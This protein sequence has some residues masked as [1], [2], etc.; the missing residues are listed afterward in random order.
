MI[1]LI[2]WGIN[3]IKTRKEIR[4]LIAGGINTVVGYGIYALMIWLNLHYMI[5]QTISTICGVIC[6]YFLNKYFTFN[7]KKKSFWELVRFITVY[8]VIFFTFNI[9]LSYVL[10]DI[11]HWHEY[12]AGFIVLICTIITSWFGHNFFSFRSKDDKKES[13][14]TQG[15]SEQTEQT[16]DS[17]NILEQT[18]S[19]KSKE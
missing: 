10:I 17:S 5:A 19:D 8:V 2:R 18:Q 3:L 9:G 4:F 16:A 13:E 12:L 1:K 6:S 7:Q 14:K 11:L 15:E